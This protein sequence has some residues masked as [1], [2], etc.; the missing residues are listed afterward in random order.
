MVCESW[1]PKMYHRQY[2][3]RGNETSK[4]CSDCINLRFTKPTPEET[5]EIASCKSNPTKGER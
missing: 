4:D 5:A 2:C 1:E 3:I